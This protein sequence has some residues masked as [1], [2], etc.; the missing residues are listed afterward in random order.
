MPDS[1]SV[2]IGI[3]QILLMGQKPLRHWSRNSLLHV[4]VDDHFH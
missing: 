1:G 2:W 4:C 3:R